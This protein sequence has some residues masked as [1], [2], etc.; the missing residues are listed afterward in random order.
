MR[1]I[2]KV[3]WQTVANPFAERLYATPSKDV[4]VGYI[5]NG[6]HVVLCIVYAIPSPVWICV[7]LGVSGQGY[8]R[9]RAIG[10]TKRWVNAKD[11]AE[12]QALAW[13]HGIPVEMVN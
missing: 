13:L 8:L 2:N 6:S 7:E 4:E 5:A 12:R 3:S 10:E 11:A 9:R 1:R